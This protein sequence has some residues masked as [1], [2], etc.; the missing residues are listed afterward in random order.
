MLHGLLNHKIHS[1][2]CLSPAGYL[3]VLLDS[4]PDSRQ[5]H[6]PSNCIVALD[7]ILDNDTTLSHTD[8]HVWFDWAAA[9]PAAVRYHGFPAR[10]PAR[11]ATFFPN[12]MLHH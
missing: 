3:T 8:S 2:A 6:H 12:H 9:P 11:K 1:A 4:V 10:R 7:G 5:T